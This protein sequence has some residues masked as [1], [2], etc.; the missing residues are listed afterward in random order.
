MAKS[1]IKLN[2]HP[3]MLQSHKSHILK[4]NPMINIRPLIDKFFSRRIKSVTSRTPKNTNMAENFRRL[5]ILG[6]ALATSMTLSSCA[7]IPVIMGANMIYETGSKIV[8]PS[9]KKVNNPTPMFHGAMFD[10]GQGL[11]HMVDIGISC[12]DD[13]DFDKGFVLKCTPTKDVFGGR[14]DAISKLAQMADDKPC[15]FDINGEV[16]YEEIGFS[17]L[18]R[19]WDFEKNQLTIHSDFAEDHGNRDHIVKFKDLPE[20]AKEKL[21][22]MRKLKDDSKGK[23]KKP[24]VNYHFGSKLLNK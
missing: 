21:E 11:D 18:A 10:M 19:I 7:Q 14:E 4:D 9:E 3:I 16:I 8:S 1:N 2:F 24:K 6:I 15:V 13:L 12:E 5:R 20:S 17:S 22:K 23:D